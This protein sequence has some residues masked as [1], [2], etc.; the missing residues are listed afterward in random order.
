MKKISIALREEDPA[1]LFRQTLKKGLAV[2]G[3]L[4][5]AA[6]APRRDVDPPSARWGRLACYLSEN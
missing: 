6:V 3:E 1:E 2:R 5:L 4:C